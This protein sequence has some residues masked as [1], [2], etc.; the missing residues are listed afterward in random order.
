MTLKFIGSAFVA[1]ALLA[2]CA[3]T[4]QAPGVVVTV[5]Y[6]PANYDDRAIQEAAT[7]QCQAK[8]YRVALPYP[9]QPNMSASPWGYKAFGCY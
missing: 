2:A 3:S 4:P 8:R 5:P 9:Q 7:E 1:A 6:D